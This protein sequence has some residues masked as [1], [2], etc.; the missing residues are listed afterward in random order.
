VTYL[1]LYHL[2]ILLLKFFSKLLS[3]LFSLFKILDLQDR[4]EEQT[5]ICEGQDIASKL[6]ITRCGH[7]VLAYIQW[8]T[9]DQYSWGAKKLQCKILVFRRISFIQYTI[10]V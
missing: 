10:Q 5:S 4:E 8:R 7:M 3:S 2:S 9:Q 6:I 1:V